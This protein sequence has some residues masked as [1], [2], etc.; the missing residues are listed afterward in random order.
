MA[1]EV[2]IASTTG[3][4]TNLSD[5]PGFK[6]GWKT[7]DFWITCAAYLVGTYLISRGQELIGG[8]L[9][10]V[11]TGGMHLSSAAAKHGQ[12]ASVVENVH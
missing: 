2:K 7:P 8:I 1:D 12:N 4:G 9:M 6:S 3:N 11:A 10:S 5:M